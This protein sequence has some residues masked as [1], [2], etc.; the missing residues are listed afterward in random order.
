MVAIGRFLL[1]IQLL[2]IRVWLLVLTLVFQNPR[3]P[4]FGKLSR[5]MYLVLLNP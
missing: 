4:F 5:V 2:L 1:V 3:P